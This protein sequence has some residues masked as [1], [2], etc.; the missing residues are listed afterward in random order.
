MTTQIKYDFKIEKFYCNL[1]DKA[2]DMHNRSF[3]FASVLR[4]F[5]ALQCD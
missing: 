5:F 3:I 1:Y 4:E 2:D